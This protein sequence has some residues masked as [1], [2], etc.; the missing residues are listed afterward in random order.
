MDVE[1][2]VF[3][4]EPHPDESFGHF[5][6]RFRRANALSDRAIADHL[7]IRVQWV[8][9]WDSPS[10]R[11]NPTSLQ[12]IA[13]SKLTEVAPEQLAKMLPSEPLHLQTRLCPACYAEVPVHRSTWQRAGNDCCDHHS[14]KLLS[15]CPNCKSEFRTPAL[16]EDAHC[17][18]CGLCFAQ[19]RCGL[20]S[21]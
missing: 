4:V 15:A 19:M 5:I 16:W 18:G 14:L 17:E 8:Q 7:G 13:L 1:S 10:R 21:N 9:D 6:G 11:R 3:R 20:S 12:L 2:W